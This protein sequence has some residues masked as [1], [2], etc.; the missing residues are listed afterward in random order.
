M[1]YERKSKPLSGRG[2]I[3]MEDKKQQTQNNSDFTSGGRLW[4]SN[5][6]SGYAKGTAQ[7][8]MP[9]NNVWLWFALIL[10]I[11]YVS[12]WFLAPRPET[13]ITV[14]Y[15]FFKEEVGKNNV[16]KIYN[17]GEN[18]SGSFKI[19]IAYSPSEEKSGAPEVEPKPLITFFTTTLPSFVDRGLETFL[20]G[21]GVEISAK[22]IHEERSFL[23][24]L[25]YSF[26]PG[27]F[28]IGFYIW[29]FRRA[30]RQG[31]G[32]GGGIMGI[33]KSK[34]RR[35]DQEK[36]TKVTFDDVAGIDE[37]ENELVE[38]VD[39]LKDPNKYTR[40]G[41]TAPKGVLLV[42]APGTGKTLLAKAVAGEAGVPFFSMSAAE[43][44]EMIVGVGAARV[45]D[46]FKEAR[47][48]APAIIFI[49]EL[50][51]IGRAR[52]QMSIGGASEQE[53]TL[54][55]I[56][57]EMDGF[58]SRNG[59]IVLAATNQPDVLDKALLRPGRFD[60]RVVV[61]L[62]DKNG[63]EAILEVHTR[64]MPLSD[65][66]SLVE[67]A[68]TTP[69]FSGADLKNLVNEAALLAARREQDDVRYKDF[70]DALEKIV[71]GPERPLL[72]SL[73][74]KECIAYHEGG[75][76]I[77]G[78]VVPGADPVNR[79]TI[80][81]RGQALGVTYQRPENDRYNYPE[82]YLRARIVGMLGGRAAEEIVYGTKTTGAESDIEQAT[83]LAYRMVTRWGMSEQLGT[84]QLAPRGNPYLT[85]SG[86]YSGAK[87][88]SEETA[89]TIDAEVLKIIGESHD[90]AKRLL[91]AYRRQ[92]DALAEALVARE[93]LD[94]Q[95]I[96]K[97]TGLPPAPV[98]AAG[99]LPVFGEDG[100]TDLL[101]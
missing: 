50:D 51:A 33:G 45:R 84:I 9:P 20:I 69:G 58:S 81:P 68:A 73:A 75:H 21:H 97:T 74:D 36:E 66:A 82:A 17:R 22:P 60:R 13:P 8:K 1:C 3:I 49:D 55:Q 34:A 57:T 46:L 40:L 28:F 92:L 15:T 88:F 76:A 56:L 53:Q 10:L 96:L 16:G 35:Y 5:K 79:V 89:K 27:L 100:H 61:N 77:L 78:L 39:F 87:P 30:A 29:L 94:E 90:E 25:F 101:S 23:A 48:H 64:N 2:K 7:K 93:T 98:L 86:G 85:G 65:D 24:T 38:I 44:V 6:K 95:D 31:G 41:G 80:M 19:P 32:M 99:K 42:G 18:I 52:G 4:P 71:L 63:R 47:E 72:L 54:N 11:N 67:L 59:I 14:P 26:G 70:L 43:F 37:A 62:P 12:A 83:G 91:K